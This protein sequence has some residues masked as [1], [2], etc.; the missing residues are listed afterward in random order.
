MP[1]TE[2]KN[3]ISPKT[4]WKI[5]RV[6]A[7]TGKN[8]WSIAQGTW[9]EEPRLAIRWNGN[10]DDLGNPQ[11]RGHPTWFILPNDLEDAVH[12]TI[13]TVE[14]SFD[15]VRCQ[16]LPHEDGNHGVWNVVLNISKNIQEEWGGDEKT[17]FFSLPDLEKRLF[18][19][20]KKYMNFIHGEIKY[21]FLDGKFEAIMYSNGI[22]ENKNPVDIQTVN[23]ALLRAVKAAIGA[24]RKS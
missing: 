22:S 6:L 4:K 16:I 11:S 13:E 20:H 8:G 3:V 7:D 24:Q 15:D 1:Y 18:R 14:Q 23:D 17:V 2:P 10:D 12:D 21:C 19:A 5:R 9:E